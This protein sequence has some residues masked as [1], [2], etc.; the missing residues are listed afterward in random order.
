[1]AQQGQYYNH[2]ILCGEQFNYSH[3]LSKGY[4]FQG[5]YVFCEYQQHT[6]RRDK[7]VR[8][9]VGILTPQDMEAIAR[10]MDLIVYLQKCQGKLEPTVR[11]SYGQHKK[12]GVLKFIPGD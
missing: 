2:A 12:D 6:R 8:V 9:G 10:L 3:I 1:M 4:T 5:H 11:K 7:S